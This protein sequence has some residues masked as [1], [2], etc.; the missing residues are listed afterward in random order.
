MLRRGSWALPWLLAACA[1]P[2]PTAEV[3]PAP[4]TPP[5]ESNAAPPA[6]SSAR[7]P[8]APSASAARRTDAGDPPVCTFDLAAPVDSIV[9]VPSG[10][11][12]HAIVPSVDAAT[13]HG[14]TVLKEGK[15]VLVSCDGETSQ[16]TW[17]DVDGKGRAT[18]TGT[19]KVLARKPLSGGREAVW[20]GTGIELRACSSED[21]F[22]AIVAVDA[23]HLSVL[24]VAE[25]SP[26]GCKD[27]MKG[28]HAETLSGE[29]V[30]VVPDR[31]GS[32]AGYNGWDEV[33]TLRDGKLRPAGKYATEESSFDMGEPPDADGLYG[34]SL[35]GTAHYADG[36]GVLDGKT[37]W[38]KRVRH[39]AG[40]EWL[41][42]RELS[43]VR[44]FGLED[45]KLVERDPVPAAE[46]PA[47]SCPADMAG[48]R[49]G[50]YFAEKPWRDV[51]VS[52]LCVDRTEVT[53]DAYAACVSARA[54]TEPEPDATDTVEKGPP[55]HPL[56]DNACNWKRPGADRHPI[57]CVDPGQATA[58]CAWAGKR[59]PTPDEWDWAARGAIQQPLHWWNWSPE[60]LKPGRQNACGTECAEWVFA[61][62]GQKAY[63]DSAA[64]RD[65]WPTTAP[66]GSFPKG[67][68]AQ[69]LLDM[70][71][72]VAEWTSSRDRE[73]H[74]VR[75]GTSW[76]NESYDAPWK[77][78]AIVGM[79]CVKGP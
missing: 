49:G 15:P 68:T 71:G 72:N 25:W 33:W 44:R 57:N 24:G 36:E 46:K 8:V 56:K 3:S 20:I 69:G 13:L 26:G 29:T 32:G 70:I 78:S 52:P 11:L 51:V 66:V 30:Y 7:A 53:V 60:N 64:G 42:P 5:A 12:A 39:D 67:A 55:E 76:F 28:M 9:H 38:H 18:P 47:P 59:L 1:K 4:L 73:S 65:A 58:Y 37:R 35:E 16:A 14:K 77:P 31:F 45:E 75:R 74:P 40:D 22:F 79:R 41:V 10:V 34:P 6:S 62:W 48:V 19:V 2:A 27:P 21:A 50:S 54:C 17:Q 23:A 63:G 61:H 43:W